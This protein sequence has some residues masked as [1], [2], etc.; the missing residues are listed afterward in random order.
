MQNTLSLARITDQDGLQHADEAAVTR[1]LLNQCPA[2]GPLLRFLQDG[3]AHVDILQG[4]VQLATSLVLPW[5]HR[6]QRDRLEE[7]LAWVFITLLL[8]IARV[9]WHILIHKGGRKS[10]FLWLNKQSEVPD[11]W[12]QPAFCCFEQCRR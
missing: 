8:Q 11:D 1:P 5:R 6:H 7:N 3:V 10:S 2:H 4:A 12:Q 9:N